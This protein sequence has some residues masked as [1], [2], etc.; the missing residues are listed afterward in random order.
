MILKYVENVYGTTII[1]IVFNIFMTC[2]YNIQYLYDY[3]N[4]NIR[5]SAIFRIW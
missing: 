2:L 1:L 4:I 5:D 3:T